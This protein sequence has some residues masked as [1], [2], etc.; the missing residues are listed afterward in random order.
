M[1]RKD[2]VPENC[3]GVQF[4]SEGCFLRFTVQSVPEGAAHPLPCP[5]LLGF[6]IESG[7][8]SKVSGTEPALRAPEVSTRTVPQT[9]LRR[10][11]RRRG[12]AQACA[13]V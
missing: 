9:L 10:L 3:E 8:E 5:Q 6:S 7:W 12:G 2:C 11:R 13:C 4:W 1:D